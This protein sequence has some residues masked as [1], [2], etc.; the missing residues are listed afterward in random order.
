MGPADELVAGTETV[1][2]YS[3]FPLSHLRI[4]RIFLFCAGCIAQALEKWEF[5][6]GNL[7]LGQ[8]SKFWRLGFPLSHVKLR[9]GNPTW[10]SRNPSH[11]WDTLMCSKVVFLALFWSPF[12]PVR[13]QGQRF[14]FRIQIQ[15]K[16]LTTF[17]DGPYS[18]YAPSAAD[19]P[20]DP[21]CHR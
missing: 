5:G 19:G 20:T 13:R 6:D 18:P 2:A 1:W 8:R 21:Y 3:T 17:Y 7:V 4:P 9:R 11:I 12:Y 15:K 10:E 14:R 16:T